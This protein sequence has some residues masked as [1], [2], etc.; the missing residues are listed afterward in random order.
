MTIFQFW[1]ERNIGPS[2]CM[3]PADAWILDNVDHGFDLECLPCPFGGRLRDAPVVLLYLS[4][5]WSKEEVRKAKDPTY[6]TV[7]MRRRRGRLGLQGPD[8]NYKSAQWWMSRTKCFGAPDKVRSKIAILNIGAYHSKT[9]EGYS[10]L[11]SLPSCRVSLDWAQNVLFP[12]AESGTRVVVCLRSANFWGLSPNTK[13]RGTLF[14]PQATRSG[15]MT[16]GKER[17]MI[18]RAA[19]NAIDAG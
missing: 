4:P 7:Y 5:G 6:Q 15:H 3:H 9:F 2:D 11:A 16:N 14:V 8:I 10:L 1:S 18:I 17:Q 12:Q 19:Q 13:Y